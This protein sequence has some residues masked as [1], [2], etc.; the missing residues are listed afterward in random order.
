[1]DIRE[2]TEFLES[3]LGSMRTHLLSKIA[4]M[5]DDWN[6]IELRQYCADE[7]AREVHKMDRRRM[8]EYRNTV[9]TTSL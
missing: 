7:F 6:G 8:R 2:K 5:P 1:M 3:F 4:A 9:I